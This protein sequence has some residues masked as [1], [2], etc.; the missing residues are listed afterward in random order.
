[1]GHGL[2]YLKCRRYAY[3]KNGFVGELLFMI[4]IEIRGFKKALGL[5]ILPWQHNLKDGK[6]VYRKKGLSLESYF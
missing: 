1:M 5:E 3:N 4:E 2:H 6:Y